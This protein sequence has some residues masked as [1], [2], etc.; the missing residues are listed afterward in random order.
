MSLRLT[1]T[2]GFERGELASPARGEQ[3]SP[4][5]GFVIQEIIE[6]L[7][8]CERVKGERACNAL[9]PLASKCCEG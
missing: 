4:L 1:R 3:S 5:M 9:T 6:V 8:G 2:R 7:L